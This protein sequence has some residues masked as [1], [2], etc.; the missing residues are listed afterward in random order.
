M[1]H[2]PRNATSGHVLHRMYGDTK[3]YYE[4]HDNRT[5]QA[6]MSLIDYNSDEA[7]FKAVITDGI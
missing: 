5:A 1:A 7:V 2:A 4:A 6:C 3:V